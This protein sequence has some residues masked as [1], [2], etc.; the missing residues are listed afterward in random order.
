[1][2][3]GPASPT[4][5][6]TAS[7]LPAY[8]TLASAWG[9]IVVA[10]SLGETVTF[11]GIASRGDAPPK[12]TISV[13]LDVPN[14]LAFDSSGDLWVANFGDRTVVEYRRQQLSG[15]PVVPALTISSGRSG[16]LNSPA[17]MA[18]DA[19]GDLWVAND[20][21]NTLVEYSKT[22]LTHGPVV[23]DVTITS[24][25]SKSLSGAVCPRLRLSR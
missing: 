16:S 8:S 12:S 6:A 14:S 3:F 9:S 4:G 21:S 20:L 18:F 24:E 15:G 17:G 5:W 13:G 19:S 11:Y 1:M 23:P 25:G 10:N 2:L 7:G 22:S